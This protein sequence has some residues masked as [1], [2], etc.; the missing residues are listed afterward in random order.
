MSRL[1]VPT[2][3]APLSQ[4]EVMGVAQSAPPIASLAA[5]IRSDTGRSKKAKAQRQP[6]VCT[7]GPLASET[8]D[9]CSFPVP[10]RFIDFE[11]P[12]NVMPGRN[13]T[14][15]YNISIHRR[16]IVVERSMAQHSSIGRARACASTQYRRATAP[17]PDRPSDV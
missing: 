2:H 14:R 3:P 16:A 7:F 1:I 8:I 15:M 10:L 11:P 4:S 13:V 6:I 5:Q 17:R 9:L 12:E